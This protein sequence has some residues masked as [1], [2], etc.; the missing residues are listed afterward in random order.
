MLI[1]LKP[2]LIP[3]DMP[4]LQTFASEQ[5]KR[6]AKLTKLIADAEALIEKARKEAAPPPKGV[7]GAERQI[8]Q[9]IND[10]Q[11][12]SKILDIRRAADSA[13]I[14]LLKAS[15]NAAAAAKIMGERHWNM[16]SVL[17]R[18]KTGNGGVVGILEA[19]QLRAAYADV[20][21]A[22]GPSELA[23]WGQ[24]AIDTADAILADSVLRENGVR[25]L[26]ERPFMSSVLMTNLNNKEHAQA[27]ALLN[28]VLDM[29]Q[30][31][32]LAYSQ[33]QRQ[34][35]AAFKRIQMGL[36]QRQR[37]NDVDESGA[38]LAADAAEGT[39]ELGR[40]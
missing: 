24:Q 20:L 22:A 31:A 9:T 28:Q 27:Q 12:N 11:T 33:F 21:A 32:G 1:D 37:I 14:E 16:W 8:I 30:Q 39:P 25:K 23:A 35:T 26:D 40:L 15:Q 10:R 36:T 4:G 34:D 38:I 13:L 3:L 5:N 18:A 7:S 6:L 29:N 19:M 2:Q 17:R